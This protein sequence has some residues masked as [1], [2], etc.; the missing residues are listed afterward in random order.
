MSFR[1]LFQIK[2]SH[3]E[4]TGEGDIVGPNFVPS[5]RAQRRLGTYF[6]E[7][8]RGMNPFGLIP[9]FGVANANTPTEEIVSLFNQFNIVKIRGVYSTE[10]SSEL[11]KLCIEKS[12]LSPFDYLDVFKGQKKG[13]TGGSPVLNDER[14]WPYAANQVVR[15]VV[16]GILGGNATEFG[17]SVAAHYS[18]RGIHRDYRQL[19]EK[20]GSE[21]HIDNPQKRIVRVLHYCA[22]TNMQGGMLGIIPYSHDSKQFSALA[23]RVGVRKPLEWFDTHRDELSKLRKTRNFSQVDEIDRHIV[24]VATDPG[25]VLVTNSAMLHCGEHMMSP[26][27]FFVST[28]TDV[29]RETLMMALAPI[30]SDTGKR[31]HKYLSALGFGGS[32]EVY[33]HLDSKNASPERI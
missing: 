16:Q 20:A 22:P 28:Y 21:Y 6:D 26:R 5:S 12:G 1:E 9:T 18:A 25:D 3:R 11:H 32:D 8:S 31:Y 29:N 15:N 23:N 14:F 10:T 30:K 17:S 13:F 27:Y 7:F 33:E 19:C 2:G 24:W 4:V